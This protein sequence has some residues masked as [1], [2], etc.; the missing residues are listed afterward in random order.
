MAIEIP[1]TRGKVAIIDDEDFEQ[2]SQYKWTALRST[3]GNVFRPV[4]YIKNSDG[5]WTSMAMYRLIMGNPEN[6]QVDHIDH[7][8]L[9][10]QKSNLRIVTASQNAQ[11]RRKF[12]NNQ[13]GYKG[14]VWDKSRYVAQ[15]TS[16]GKRIKLG[17]FECPIEAAKAYNAAAIELHGEFACLNIINEMDNQSRIIN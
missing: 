14:V 12:A 16:K 9:N 7:Q 10:N 4:T 15:I 13:S 2:V 17:R 3:T 1:L 5:N 6:L 8:P 11:H